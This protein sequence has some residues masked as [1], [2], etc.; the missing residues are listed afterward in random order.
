MS[1]GFGY[2][3]LLLKILVMT[4]EGVDTVE[5]RIFASVFCAIWCDL[6]RRVP[7]GTQ[8]TNRAEGREI[9]PQRCVLMLCPHPLGFGVS[10]TTAHLCPRPPKYPLA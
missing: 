7:E 9:K 8:E 4:L 1:C 10:C 5:V 2:L 3:D 6:F